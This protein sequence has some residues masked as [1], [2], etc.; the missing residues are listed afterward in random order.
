MMKKEKKKFH[1][2]LKHFIVLAIAILYF[3]LCFFA[4][5][6]VDNKQ[7]EAP[8]IYLVF[9]AEHRFSYSDGKLDEAVDW[10]Q[11]FG[12][13]KF[14]SYSDG[15]YLGQ[16]NLMAY[17]TMIYLF[18]D[19]NDSVAYPGT[20]FAY[21]A[22]KKIGV[23]PTGFKELDQ[24]IKIVLSKLIDGNDR[25]TMPSDDELTMLQEIEV[26]LDGDSIEEVVYAINSMG[27]ENNNQ[28]FSFLCYEKNG[29]LYRIISN[30]NSTNDSDLMHYYTIAQIMDLDDDGTKELIVRDVQY[31]TAA[32][33]K[34]RIYKEEDGNY[35]MITSET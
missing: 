13:R 3:I 24:N 19:Q 16:Y 32:T 22:D 17:N 21:A 34:Y 12:T 10:N 23:V 33:E 28:Q 20:L 35:R 1:F 25:M 4:F 6:T 8:T 30:T 18:D 11:I 31:G 15:T 9:D 5:R 26:D 14:Y 29:E 2:Q 27:G 7:E